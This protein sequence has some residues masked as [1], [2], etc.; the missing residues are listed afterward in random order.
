MKP[1]MSIRFD[2]Q[3]SAKTDDG[4]GG[5]TFVWSTQ[6]RIVGRMKALR[7]YEQIRAKA[8]E[9]K[10]THRIRTWYDSR[11]TTAHR[12]LYGSRIFDIVNIENID[13]RNHQL[14]I[15]VGE[16]SG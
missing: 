16:K 10:V 1:A 11:I 7:G 14:T 4:R 9:E 8:L 6:F 3:S 13:E 12:L 5:T 2:V 15:T